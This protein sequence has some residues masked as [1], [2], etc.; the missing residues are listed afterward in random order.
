MRGIS[1]AGRATGWQS[2]GQGFESPILH[3]D[4]SPYRISVRAFFARGHA[5]QGATIPI[6]A[7][8]VLLP[9]PRGEGRGEG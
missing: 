7:A 1:S 2:V 6:R 8:F 5:D 3:L 4:E 9:L